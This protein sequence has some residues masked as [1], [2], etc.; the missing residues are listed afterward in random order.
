M[1][2]SG[3]FCIFVH[4]PQNLQFWVGDNKTPGNVVTVQKANKSKHLPCCKLKQGG[5]KNIVCKTS[6]KP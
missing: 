2:V 3:F 1:H 4:R 6:F 5:A